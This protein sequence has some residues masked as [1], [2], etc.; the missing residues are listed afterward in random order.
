VEG[1]ATGLSYHSKILFA[2]NCPAAILPDETSKEAAM[3]NFVSHKALEFL[4]TYGKEGRFVLQRFRETWFGSVANPLKQKSKTFDGYVA[5]RQLN[6]GAACV[7]IFPSAPI[8]VRNTDFCSFS[9]LSIQR[10]LPNAC[11]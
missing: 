3:A 8:F 11:I 5:Q 7:S 2:L 9:F 1:S 4:E 10:L 6:V